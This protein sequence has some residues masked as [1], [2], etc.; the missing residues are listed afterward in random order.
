MGKGFDLSAVS[1]RSRAILFATGSGIS[2]ARAVGERR[3]AGKER[4]TLYYGTRD[5]EATA[6]AEESATGARNR[7]RVLGR[8][9][10]ARARRASRGYRERKDRRRRH[11]RGSVRTK[12]DGGGRHRAPRRRRRA[13]GR[14]GDEF[15]D[16]RSFLVLQYIAAFRLISI[17]SS[18]RTEDG[19][20]LPRLSRALDG[21]LERAMSVAELERFMEPTR[22]MGTA[23]SS[24][25]MISD[26]DGERPN[27]FRENGMSRMSRSPSSLP[28]WKLF[29]LLEREAARSA[30]SPKASAWAS[31]AP[32]STNCRPNFC[33]S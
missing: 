19:A 3:L 31:L 22:C 29:M 7:A 4:V 15:L 16:A 11:V 27:G 32:S 26:L 8:E 28:P 13:K 17:V 1:D 5:V 2:R 33:D 21:F 23:P 6:L 24:S 10:R 30:P 14:D 25:A 12:G 9:R 20:P 18:R